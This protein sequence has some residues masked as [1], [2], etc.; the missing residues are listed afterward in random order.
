M[1][2]NNVVL[3]VKVDGKIL[4]EF[5][6][7]VYIPFGSEYSILLK[8]LSNQR[9]KVSVSIDGEDVL[10]GD[11]LVVN[12]NESMDLKRFV[13]NGNLNEGN[14]FKFIEKS[15]KIVAHRGN[16]ADDGLITISYEFEVDYKMSVSG[17][18]SRSLRRVDISQEKA[19]PQTLTNS[20]M[21]NAA[22]HSAG[23]T[24]PGSVNS[25]QFQRVSGFIGDGKKHTMTMQ[26]LGKV[27]SGLEVTAPVTVTRLTAC[28]MCGTKVRQTDKFCHECGASVEIV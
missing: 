5:G 18:L 11:S 26:L 19:Y 16:K 24:A 4:R 20:P 2:K 6:D 3:A 15:D 25:Q 7:T 14:S 22:Y 17:G 8:N 28:S 13:R 10:D 12:A 27:D 9:V 23:I 21:L 1:F